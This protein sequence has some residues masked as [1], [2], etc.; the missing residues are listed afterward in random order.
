M[1][2]TSE[3]TTQDLEGRLVLI[4]S[5]RGFCVWL[6]GP[7]GRLNV[8]V[9]SGWRSKVAF[10]AGDHKEGAGDKYSPRGPTGFKQVPPPKFLPSFNSPS[11]YE[12]ISIDLTV[13][14]EPTWSITSQSV[15]SDHWCIWGQVW[16]SGP[17]QILLLI[18]S[19]PLTIWF[20]NLYLT[21]SPS[22]CC[23]F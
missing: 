2:K 1:A 11:D 15:F 3:K 9:W 13:G 5:S 7:E 16:G 4:H 10:E 6:L 19:L 20:W 23:S 14:S 22:H 17:K 12:P 18:I 8:M 21:F